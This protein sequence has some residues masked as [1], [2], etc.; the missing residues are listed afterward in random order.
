MRA[1]PAGLAI[2][3]YGVV[4]QGTQLLGGRWVDVAI[5]VGSALVLYSVFW[6]GNRLFLA[7]LPRIAAGV[8]QL[9]DVVEAGARTVVVASIVVVGACEELFWRGFVQERKGFVIALA[10]Y[11]VVHV[12]SRRWALVFAAAVAGAAWG[13]LF[14][15][16]DSLVAPLVSHV[17]WDLALVLWWPM[18]TARR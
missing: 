16:R 12:P 5:G 3:A 14:A 8:G 15:W 4:A 6:L 7:V 2:G 9:Y 17:L 1:L 13:G 11:T 18:R 10:A